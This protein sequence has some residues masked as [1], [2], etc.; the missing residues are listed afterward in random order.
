VAW[1]ESR[2]LLAERSIEDLYRRLRDLFDQLKMV[3]Q[4]MRALGQQVPGGGNTGAAAGFFVCYP[5]TGVA[6]ATWTGG[7][8]TA[9]APF[10]AVVCQVSSTG[11]DNLGSKACYNWLA[12][13]L[14]A[15]KG[16]VCLPDGAGAYGVVSQS[17]T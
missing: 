6:G 10:P 5:T 9:G 3:R 11:I 12:S 1:I 7:V 4:Q 17:C 14:V 15:N 8:P 2:I 13:P 16:C